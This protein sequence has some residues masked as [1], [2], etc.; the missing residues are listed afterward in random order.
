MKHHY[1]DCDVSFGITNRV[2]DRILGTTPNGAHASGARA[3][4]HVD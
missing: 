4:A 2:L 3:K 1:D